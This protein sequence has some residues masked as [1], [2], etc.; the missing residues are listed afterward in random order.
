MDFRV[1]KKEMFQV[2]IS[3]TKIKRVDALL[4]F[5]LG[6]FSLEFTDDA[7]QALKLSIKN[8]CQKFD[9]RWSRS[10]RHLDRFLKENASWLDK[11]FVLPFKTLCEIPSS[12]NTKSVGRPRKSFD[13]CC[14]KIKKLKVQPLLNEYSCDEIAAAHEINLRKS[15]KRDT[16]NVLKKLSNSSP[17]RGW[18]KKK[19]LL[20]F[21]IFIYVHFILRNNFEKVF[22][23]R[24]IFRNELIC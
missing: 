11:H 19:Y 1:T 6:F 20:I 13:D 12:S 3:K 4:L 18:F 15:G 2:W 7:I 8:L 22:R 21:N 9:Q 16:A 23:K 24:N 5:V 10:S 14:D 17:H